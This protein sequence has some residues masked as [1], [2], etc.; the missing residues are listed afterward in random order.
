MSEGIWIHAVSL[1]EV[2]ATTPFI[3][4]LRKQFPDI[5][6]VVSTGT[7]TGRE[8]VKQQ[9]G[10]IAEHCYL[11]LDFPWMI[12]RHI[13]TL[14]PKICIVVETE[15]WPNLF[16]QLHRHGVPSVL[17][18]GR[19]S[20][21]SFHRYHMIRCFMRSVLQCLSVCLMQ[22]DRDVQQ[23]VALGAH[24]AAVHRTGNMKFDQPENLSR[25]P[26]MQ[27]EWVGATPEEHLIVAGSTHAEEDI[28]LLTMYKNLLQDRP[29]VLL[30]IAPRHL[31][32]M[33]QLEATI[34]Q[35]GFSIVRRSQV[36]KGQQKPENYPKPRVLILDSQGELANAY[37]LG[38]MAFVG[39]TL[40][41]IGGHNLLEPA[42]WGI[43]VIFGP[44][45]DHCEETANLLIQNGG[46]IRVQNG[47]ELTN[48]CLKGLH[49]S[50]WRMETGQAAQR[51]VHMNQGVVKKNL[52]IITPLL[53]I[54]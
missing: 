42:R 30:L 4:A 43:P 2:M 49:N 52:Q 11:P 45:T 34:H 53:D 33:P 26:G 51:V 38:C 46:G 41:P 25:P 14:R 54:E 24:P 3:Q 47:E 27:P 6:L 48:I 1:G 9:L 28:L 17:I 7:E 50:I 35:N 31:E 23:L 20:S 16:R 44:Y 8:A 19:I 12:K 15:L 5:P 13:Q 29:D 21:R 40:A 10:G 36:K 32:R 39:G 22:S 37:S 18:N